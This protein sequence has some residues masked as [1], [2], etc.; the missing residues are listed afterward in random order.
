VLGGILWILRRCARLC[1]LPVE[2]PSPSTC[3][4]LE[5]WRTFAWRGNFR[6]LTVRYDRSLAVYRGLFHIVC[7]MMPLR[8][9]LQ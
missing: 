2:F 8:R 4:R 9:V 1:E 3:W 7:F 6:R 5:I